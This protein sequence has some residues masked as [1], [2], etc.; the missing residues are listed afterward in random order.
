MFFAFVQ[1]RSSNSDQR[2]LAVGEPHIQ[3]VVG[4]TLDVWKTGWIKFLQTRCAPLTYHGAV[5]RKCG[6]I[7]EGAS[8]TTP[9]SRSIIIQSGSEESAVQ[10]MT[11]S[12]HVS[13]T[14]S[15]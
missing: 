3:S 14:V 1:D 5:L 13:S 10:V 2:V 15:L 11:A 12:T 6:R 8:G 9:G 7:L 4:S